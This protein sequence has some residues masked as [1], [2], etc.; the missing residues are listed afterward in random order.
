[1]RSSSS[2]R[3]VSMITGIGTACAQPAAHLE[4]VDHGQHQ[5][6]HHQIGQVAEGL[7]QARPHHRR[8]PD[9]EALTF[10]VAGHHL[11]QHRS[12]STTS[13]RAAEASS[14]HVESGI[15]SGWYGDTG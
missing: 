9:D 4:A 2:P 3:A 15:D 14:A 7:G 8:P 5:V 11:G 6:E 12:S 1:M 10:E 13:T